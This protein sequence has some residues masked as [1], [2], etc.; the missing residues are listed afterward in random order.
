MPDSF[1]NL[2]ERRKLDSF[3]NQSE[4][5]DATQFPQSD[6]FYEGMLNGGGKDSWCSF[7]S[8]IIM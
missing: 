3:Y 6:S 4:M 5:K 1:P 8:E 2:W 7:Q